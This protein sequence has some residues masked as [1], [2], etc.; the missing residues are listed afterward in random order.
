[1]KKITLLIGLCISLHLPAQEAVSLSLDQAID[2][3][4]K[5]STAS[6][7]AQR[8]IKIARKK[9][10]ETIATGLPQLDIQV[11]YQHWLKQQVSLI[12]AEFFGGNVG[13]FAEVSFGTQQNMTASATLKQLIFDGSYIVGIQSV[14]TYL[15]IAEQAQEKTMMGLRKAVINAYGNVLLSEESIRILT[16]NL[17]S[18][19]KTLEETERVYENGLIEEESVE[20]LKITQASLKSQLSRTVKLSKIAYKMLNI[21]LGIGL[22]TAVILTDDLSSLTSEASI[23]GLANNDFSVLDHI[24]YRIAKNNEKSKALLLRLAQSKSLPSLESFINV[25]YQSYGE[26]FDFFKQEQQWFDSSLL[27]VRLKIPVFS[28]LERTAATQQARIEL[29]KA[30]TN[31][32][33][34]E[35]ELTVE[36]AAAKTDYDYSREAFTT[37]EQN[38]RLAKRIE[39]KQQVKFKEG[40]SSSFE[41][42]EAQRQLYAMQQGYLESMLNIIRSK[43]VLDTALNKPLSP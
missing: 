42:A 15:E 22:D 25:G 3:A 37:A 19:T 33:Q 7:N 26:S 5:N 35:Q 17:H 13:E 16:G 23:S 9:K 12:P 29:D 20:Q 30:Q 14:Y 2:Y 24:D 40:L 8:D 28:S 41:L 10:Q 4:L 39:Q 21:T 34:Q 6:V 43:A 36:L 11:D 27:G 18:L 32:W 38:L 31:T 1:M